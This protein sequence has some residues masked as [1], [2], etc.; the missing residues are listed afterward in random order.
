LRAKFRALAGTRC[1]AA[2]LDR[3]WATC[4]GV[5]HVADVNA[6]TALFAPDA[7]S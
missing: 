4:G 1:S 7:G 5:A 2:T 6:I 3:L